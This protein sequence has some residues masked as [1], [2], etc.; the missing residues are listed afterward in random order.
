MRSRSGLDRIRPEFFVDL[1]LRDLT[2]SLMLRGRRQNDRHAWSP[3]LGAFDPRDIGVPR[4]SGP[5]VATKPCRTSL[6]HSWRGLIFSVVVGRLRRPEG[7]DRA[8]AKDRRF[9]LD[10]YIKLYMDLNGSCEEFR[11]MRNHRSGFTLIELLVVIAIIS[12]L[13][14][15]LL[16]AVQ[17]A[18]EAAPACR[19]HYMTRISNGFQLSL[20]R[21]NVF[22]NWQPRIPSPGEAESKSSSR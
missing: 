17:S 11:L 4:S 18:R 3:P 21:D 7:W 14:V 2:S 20:E 10:I 13:I 22:R 5:R 1:L 12:V 19:G 15:L 9:R 6:T 16:P 8:G